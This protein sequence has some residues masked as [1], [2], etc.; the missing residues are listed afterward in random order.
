MGERDLDHLAFSSAGR[1][2]VEVLSKRG[3]IPSW[4][5]LFL[6]TSL[7]EPRRGQVAERAAAA[8]WSMQDLEHSRKPNRNTS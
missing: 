3:R 4:E 7:W 1:A 2:G 5:K 8:I 6:L